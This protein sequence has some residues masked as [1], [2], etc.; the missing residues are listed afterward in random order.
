M[1]KVSIKGGEQ[2]NKNELIKDLRMICTLV[3]E[4]ESIAQRYMDSYPLKSKIRKTKFE[5]IFN[6]FNKPIV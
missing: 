2:M 1:K 3:R 6:R 4:I 5:D